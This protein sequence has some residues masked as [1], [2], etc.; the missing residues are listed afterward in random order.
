M[1]PRSIRRAAERRQQKLARTAARQLK[2]QQAPAEQTEEFDFTP[3]PAI[4]DAKLAANRTNAQLSTG[5]TSS[6]GLAKSCMNAVKTA[7]TG[8]TV[9]LPTDDAAA[10]EQH[11][12]DFEAECKPATPQEC[13]LVQSLADTAWRLNR[14]PA[15]EYAIFARGRI[16]FADKFKDHDPDL[17]SPLLELE[18]FLAY[19]KQLRNLQI[20]E[21]RLHRRREKDMAELRRLQD[22]R[23]R[24]ERSQLARVDKLTAQARPATT[25][26]PPAEL[27]FEFSF[28]DVAALREQVMAENR[29]LGLLEIDHDRP[30]SQPQAA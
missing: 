22:E 14:I 6:A 16:E 26:F 27:G 3:E 21:A 8:R 11:L 15:L 2:N 23:D 12:R 29:A 30:Q 19:E 4:S 13:A 10:Y 7:L 24:R 25:A 9:L 18:I 5:P 17:R 28:A 20:Q 1:S